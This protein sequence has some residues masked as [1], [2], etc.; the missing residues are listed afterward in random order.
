MGTSRTPNRDPKQVGTLG[1]QD[2]CPKD[3][4]WTPRVPQMG[5]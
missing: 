2:G 3:P 5:C 1:I 4:G